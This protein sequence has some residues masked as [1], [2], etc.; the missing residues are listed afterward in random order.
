M[1]N[2]TEN[3]RSSSRCFVTAVNASPK[4]ELSCDSISEP[5]RL[6]GPDGFCDWRIVPSQGASWLPELE[7]QLPLGWPLTFRS[8][9]SRYL[10][11]SFECGPLQFYSVGVMNPG[12]DSNEL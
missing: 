2:P 1:S 8:L 3:G 10:Y 7:G 12:E 4:V 5:C 6:V 9:L 11:P